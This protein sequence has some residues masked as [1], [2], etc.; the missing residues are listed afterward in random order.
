VRR[1]YA[2]LQAAFAAYRD[3]L[4]EMR[5]VPAVTADGVTVE[6]SANIGKIADAET[7]VLFEAEGVGLYRTEF[8]FL[9]CDRFPTEEE[10]YRIY[11]GVADRMRPRPVVIRALDLGSD[12]A[13]PYFPRPAEAN[14]ALGQRGTRLLLRHPDLLRAQLG[15]I[16]RV[17]ATHPVRVLLPM[18][19]AVEEV[20]AVKTILEDV[21]DRLRRER[22]PFDANLPV[23]V[24]IETAAAAIVAGDL[25]EEADFLSVGTNDLVQYVLSADRTSEDM[26]AYHE[27]LHPAVV[28][29]IHA[30]VTAARTAGKK[31][32]VCGEM[33]GN[34]AYTELLLGLGVRSLSVTPGEILAIKKVVRS[35][36]LARAGQ[37]AARVLELKTVHDIKTCC[38]TFGVAFADEL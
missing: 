1:E 28:R 33:A 17:G 11:A 3:S 24:M 23:G 13:L 5:D 10:Q 34:A 37:L 25:A 16:L 4:D 12:K 30:V 8:N 36:T 35:I 32:S 9:V 6:L 14:P 22:V 38:R 31:L 27:P 7:A 20:I 15:A 29:T 21:K 2:R 18:I 19:G 26:I